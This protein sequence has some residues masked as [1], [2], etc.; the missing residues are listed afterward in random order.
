MPTFDAPAERFAA[1]LS[2][3]AAVLTHV[4]RALMFTA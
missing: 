3:P 4:N 1:E 2:L